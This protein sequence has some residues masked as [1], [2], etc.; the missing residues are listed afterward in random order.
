MAGVGGGAF[1]GGGV[2]SNLWLFMGCI[3]FKREEGQL[4]WHQIHFAKYL[5]W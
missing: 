1:G 4:T 2:K 3:Y 5:I